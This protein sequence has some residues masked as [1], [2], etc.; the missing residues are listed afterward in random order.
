MEN[1]VFLELQRRE[2]EVYYYKT[3]DGFEVDFA[4]KEGRG[5]KE[6]IQVSWSLEKA[7]VKE[8]ELRALGTAM[9]ELRINRSLILT[10]DYEETMRFEKKTIKALPVY[11]W[12]ME[13]L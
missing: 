4:V 11:K 12:L 6:L 9:K 13:D 2:K 10:D 5:I 8:R 7:D 1:L 3:K